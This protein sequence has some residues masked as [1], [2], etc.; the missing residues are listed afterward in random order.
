M[1]L[2]FQV[3]VVGPLFSLDLLLP[4]P[5]NRWLID[6]WLINWT[7]KRSSFQVGNLIVGLHNS[8]HIT[9]FKAWKKWNIFLVFQNSSIASNY[10][11]GKLL[12]APSNIPTCKL[13][14]IL[15][16]KELL[17]H[18]FC[19][20]MWK[21]KIGFKGCTR[22]MANFGVFINQSWGFRKPL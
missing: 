13:F 11:M 21:M 15:I 1:K 3:I 6:H 5:F 4:Q 9:L 7:M 18:M 14:F 10:S 20:L 22:S 12:L 16:W 2:G 8:V 19:K 17:Q